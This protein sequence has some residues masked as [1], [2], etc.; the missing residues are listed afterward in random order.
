MMHLM[1]VLPVALFTNFSQ[2]LDKFDVE[3][4][5]AQPDDYQRVICYKALDVDNIC[6]QEVDNITLQCY[7]SHIEHTLKEKTESQVD[8]I[9]VQSS[10][11]RKQ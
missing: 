6:H 7:R 9:E 8:V 11:D 4:C 3:V 1:K 5:E 2:A 10:P